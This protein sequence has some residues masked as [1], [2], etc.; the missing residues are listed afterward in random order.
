MKELPNNI[1]VEKKK[2][3]LKEK[4]DVSFCAVYV[5]CH[6]R[7]KWQLAVFSD[8]VTRQEVTFVLENITTTFFFLVTFR[9]F[10]M[11]NERRKVLS[12]KLFYL[13][14]PAIVNL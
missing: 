10:F 9:F 4:S 6:F 3:T 8:G 1:Q 11:L 12:T 13:C 5:S 7:L 14:W 2:P